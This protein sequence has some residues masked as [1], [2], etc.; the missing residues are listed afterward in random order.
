MLTLMLAALTQVAAPQPTKAD[1]II[2]IGNRAE[3]ELAACLARNCPPAEEV[4]KSLQASV[5]QFGA[6]RYDDAQQ[7]LQRA[8]GRNRRYAAQLPGPVS[9][10][11]ATLATVAEHQGREDLW[12][13]AARENVSLLR[14][15]VGET[16]PETLQQEL[17]FADTITGLQNFQLAS[18]MYR[19]IQ[20]KAA[21]SGQRELAAVSAFRRAW[22]AMLEERDDQAVRLAD[23]AVA[24][25]GPDDKITPQ[26]GQ[27]LRARIAI[28]RG[29]KDA[30]DQLASTL[31]Q[32]ATSTP[33]MLWQPKLEDLNLS[34]D[35]GFFNTNVRLKGSDL[36][37]ADVG[38]WVRPDGRTSG[39]EILRTSGLGQWSG[40]ITRQVSGRRYIPLD[41]P[42]SS[43]GIYRIDRFT[44]RAAFDVP[45]GT[46][47]AQRMGRME[48]HIIDLTDTDAMS[49]AARERESEA[50]AAKAATPTT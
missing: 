39:V 19:S 27:I 16:R 41:L 2:V 4:E 22:L 25:A 9:S 32:S 47:I 49:A 23:Q 28:R 13:S 45:T 31:R 40:A 20:E 29:D 34:S 50:A 18:G 7:T 24:I 43:Q 11:Y 12:R 44:V 3:K 14:Q 30:V 21:G 38:Y 26:L 48:V 37:Y 46:R 35:L 6:A 17:A 15:Y 10:L 1:D 42:A 33:R 36:M 5:E 8:I